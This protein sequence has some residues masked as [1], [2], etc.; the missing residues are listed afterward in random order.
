MVAG[1]AKLMGLEELAPDKKRSAYGKLC[2][3]VG[4]VLN[5]LLFIGKF[6][7]G[8]ISNSIAI[9]ADAFNNLSDAGSSLVTLIGFKL[10]E[11]KPDS[12]HPFGHGRM[13]YLS[14]LIVSAVILMMG[15]ELVKDSIDKIIHPTGVDFS[16]VV[17]VILVASIIGKCYMAL[18]NYKY[19]KRFESSTL[20]ATAVDSLSDC[21]STTVVLIA[22]VIGYYTDV[23]IDGFCGIAVGILIFVAGINAAKETLSPLLGEAPDPEFVNEIEEIVLNFD[24]ESVVGIHDLI[25]HDYGPGRR[26]ISLHAEVPAEGD[27]LLLHDVIDNLEMKL[28]DDLGCL[29]TIHMDPVVTKDERVTELKARCV[30]LV[31]GIGESLSLHDFRVVFGETH[32]NLIFDVVVPFEFYLSDTETTKLIQE[33]VWEHFGKN[34]FVVITI[35]KPAV[36]V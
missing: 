15:F 26:I 30:E 4:I 33:K 12:D 10:A 17:L 8:W 19:G 7:A 23:Q 28:R 13:E 21:I 5:I 1:L 3:T 6:V 11:Q 29:T 18:F 24:K 34:Y 25:V 32:T 9:T 27:I 36:K 22:T 31:K 14:G 2:G 20:K 35:D 16:V